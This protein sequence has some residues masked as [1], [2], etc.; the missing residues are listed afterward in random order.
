MID[1]TE[2]LPASVLRRLLLLMVSTLA[3]CLLSAGQASA[4]SF[5][6]GTLAD[7]PDAN[8]ADPICEAT[9]GVGDC[10]LRA[11]VE[12]ANASGA[13]DEITFSVSG[14]HT[15]TLGQLVITTEMSVTGNGSG[16]SGTVISGN[17]VSR[18]IAVNTGSSGPR[19]F[20]NSLR[21]QGG[22]GADGFAGGGINLRFSPLT[23]DHVVITGNTTN[24]FGG[25]LAGDG[26]LTMIDSA[27]VNNTVTGG[28]GVGGGAI[29]SESMRIV[30]GTI[31]GNAA[32]ETDSGAG[33]GLFI[34]N[35]RPDMEILN[36]TISGN[37]A[38][39]RGGGG[40]WS[41]VSL[42]ITNSTIV[43]NT[44]TGGTGG[45][46]ANIG[47][48]PNQETLE[49]AIVANNTAPNCG[50]EGVASFSATNS[51]DSGASCGF[52]NANGNKS[53]TDPLLGI[54][55]DN[56]GPTQTHLPAPNS[57]AVNAGS[58]DCGSPPATSGDVSTDQRGIARPQGMVCDIGSVE[59][60]HETLTVTK[61]GTGSGT[62]T[63]PNISCGADCTESY[64]DGMQVTLT[65]TADPGS[66]FT[67]WSGCDS[68]NGNECTV[69]VDGAEA[70][71]ATFD[72]IPRTLTVIRAGSGSGTV[73]GPNID[74]G[75]D[76]T[77]TQPHGTVVTLTA[78]A[79]PGSTFS[80][81]ASCDNPAGN[82]CTV[83]LDADET[84][85]ATFNLAPTMT[86]PT[87]PAALPTPTTAPFDLAAA[88]K[89]CKK[90]K[91]KK[92]RKKCRRRARQR[93]GL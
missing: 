7:G 44:A 6:V 86:L 35:Q 68:F 54:L 75:T 53:T 15:L 8:T 62:V 18:V 34:Q 42:E 78:A 82:Q 85:T 22:N 80:G 37:R 40:I 60:E 63:G 45:I 31:S 52:G 26:P 56:G 93:A 64:P 69:T 90:K 89:K 71:T 30:R 28:M 36:S 49:N 24:N 39:T 25:G 81:W 59:L 20:L 27:I 14:Q 2:L 5:A 1:S 4:A 41:Q 47:A 76:C 58:A 51:I 84:V 77:D 19:V 72:P 23:L 61:M 50:T 46:H 38:G 9:S 32:G 3:A 79:A 70:V 16:P 92:A 88:L 65:A 66:S 33:G 91:R 17:N 55:A 11:A 10:T 29:I 48:A 13:A 57:P 67:G 87:P 21:V 12:Q 43:G 74:C 83:N 73:T